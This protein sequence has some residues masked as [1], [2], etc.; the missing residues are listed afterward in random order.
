MPRIGGR[1]A[2]FGPVYGDLNDLAHVS[3]HDLARALVTITE[4]EICAPTL[5]PQYNADLCKLLYGWHVYFIVEI[6]RQVASIFEEIFGEGANEGEE[7]WLILAIFTLLK[8]KAIQ[9]P[10]GVDLGVAAPD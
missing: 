8:E 3:Q 6:A 5:V 4:G 1:L 7:N 9:P 2:G 10:E